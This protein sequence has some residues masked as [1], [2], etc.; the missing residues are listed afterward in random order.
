MPSRGP[1]ISEG[2]QT[3]SAR[4]TEIKDVMEIR[5]KAIPEVLELYSSDQ[6]KK[7]NYCTRVRK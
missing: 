6:A 1:A 2:A 3:R 4:F 7:H 5:Q